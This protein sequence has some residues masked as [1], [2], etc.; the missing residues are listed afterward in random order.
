MLVLS[1]LAGSSSIL[2]QAFLFLPSDLR[3]AMSLFVY[4]GMGYSEIASI[5]QCSQKA[6]E[7]R[8]YRARQILKERLSEFIS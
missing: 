6:V 3:E 4:E 8:I 2:F 7:T 5:S 1:L